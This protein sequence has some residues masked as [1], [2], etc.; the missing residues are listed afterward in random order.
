MHGSV[1]SVEHF[2]FPLPLELDGTV[3]SRDR[4]LVVSIP[5]LLIILRPRAHDLLQVLPEGRRLVVD[6]DSS[7]FQSPIHRRRVGLVIVPSV[8]A[9]LLVMIFWQ[10]DL[11]DV[12]TLIESVLGARGQ[13]LF[14]GTQ[15]VRVSLDLLTRPLER[16]LD[17]VA[18][19]SFKFF[20]VEPD[21]V[22]LD[23]SS[24]VGTSFPCFGCLV[25]RNVCAS[26]PG[27]I[28]VRLGDRGL[29]GHLRSDLLA[30]LVLLLRRL[31]GCHMFGFLGEDGVAL[32][33]CSIKASLLKVV[34]LEL[35]D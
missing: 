30:L 16:R 23:G 33:E 10:L 5:S 17:R 14:V 34:G 24:E 21:V 22:V 2:S 20:Q 26:P 31:R 25:L 7:S 12:E 4:L 6:N 32:F 13:T 9:K 28:S 19:T 18:L 1:S 29:S 8:R 11:V 15:A 35:Q 27:R 3:H